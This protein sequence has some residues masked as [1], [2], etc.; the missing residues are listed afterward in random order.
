MHGNNSNVFG[1]PMRQS[2]KCF[3]SSNEMAVAFNDTSLTC[4][5]SGGLMVS[6]L[7][8]GS[9]GQG[10][11]S[12]PGRGHCVIFFGEFNAGGSPALD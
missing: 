9:S 10:P 3:A 2:I 12:C 8:S 4:G 6:A 7:D 1:R 5:R 11:G